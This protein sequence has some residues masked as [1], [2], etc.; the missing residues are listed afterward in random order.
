MKKRILFFLSASLLMAETM[1][2]TPLDIRLRD[3]AKSDAIAMTRAAES[4][5]Y[6]TLLAYTYPK[7]IEKGGGTDAMLQR[8]EQSE[9]GEFDN[10]LMEARFFAEKNVYSAN[11]ELHTLI[12]RHSLYHVDG[13]PMWI[14]SHLLA[15]TGDRGRHWTFLEAS[16]LSDEL[17]HLLFQDFNIRVRDQFYDFV[18]ELPR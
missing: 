10:Q 6:K 16:S 1:K 12:E 4:K 7:L 17:I 14:R 18:H 13:K 15:V 11:G 9:D 3:R 2:P 8:M 5:D